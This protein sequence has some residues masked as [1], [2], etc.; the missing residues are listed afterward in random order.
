MGTERHY[1]RFCNL[2]PSVENMI[3]LTTTEQSANEKVDD[4][5]IRAPILG[6]TSLINTIN[7]SIKIIAPLFVLIFAIRGDFCR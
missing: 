2:D 5:T 6:E 4:K 7:L 3:K 1:N